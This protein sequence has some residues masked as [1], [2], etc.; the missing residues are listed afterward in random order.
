M[1]LFKLSNHGLAIIGVLVAVLWGVLLMEKSLNASA[2]RDYEEVQ[3]SMPATPAASKPTLEKPGPLE[4]GPSD[5]SL[6]LD[7]H[8]LSPAPRA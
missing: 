2:Q 3:R 1:K 8:P 6:S 7:S 5:W 4:P